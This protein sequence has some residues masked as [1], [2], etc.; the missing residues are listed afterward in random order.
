MKMSITITARYCPTLESVGIEGI[1]SEY[2]KRKNQIDF[3]LAIF[4]VLHV[5][6]NCCVPT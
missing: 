6:M 3:D 2:N 1:A 5:G 4:I